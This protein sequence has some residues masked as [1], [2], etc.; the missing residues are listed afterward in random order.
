[1]STNNCKTNASMRLDLFANPEFSRGASRLTEFC[2]MLVS[3]L[4]VESWLPG[5]WWRCKI[6]CAFGAKIDK[7]VI[8]KPRI[9]VKFPWR[10]KVGNH[11]WLGEGVWIDNLAEVTIGSHCCLSQGA[12]L[13]TGS[14]DWADPK[15]KLIT[16]SI[17]LKDECWVGAK[18]LL[19]PGTI[20]ERGSVVTMGSVA[21]GR[22]IA[23]SIYTGTPAKIIKERKIKRL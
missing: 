5:S 9:R 3:G 6:L 19:G 4:L 8:I 13:C 7:G 23:L 14:H 10:L 12:Y 1:M 22:L 18:T 20:A 16:A 17:V 11:S 15:F 21:S 2:W